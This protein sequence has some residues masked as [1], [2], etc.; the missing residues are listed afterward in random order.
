MNSISISG[1]L[2]RDVELRT[3]PNGVSVSYF[4]VAV[5]RPGEKDKTDF[6]DC[7]AWRSTAEFTGKYF[8]KGDPIEVTG[9]L[10]NREYEDK[11]GTKRRVVE[12]RCERVS[13]TKQKAKMDDDNRQ[14]NEPSYT[15][16]IPSDIDDEELPF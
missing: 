6:F 5:D 13:F 1:R 7:V 16:R 15:P 8:H 11:N 9:V 3:T 10:T 2:T 12:I 14:Y 4:S